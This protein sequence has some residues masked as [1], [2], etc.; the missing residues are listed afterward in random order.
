MKLITCPARR[1]KRQFGKFNLLHET[2]HIFRWDTTVMLALEEMQCFSMWKCWLE[3][4]LI[5]QDPS[6]LLLMQTG[7]TSNR[8]KEKSKGMPL[9]AKRA[10]VARTKQQRRI[11]GKSANKQF[12]GKKAWK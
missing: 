4:R 1:L 7:G 8:Q 5:I 3:G 10:I 2:I 9:A 12:R 6:N 11:K